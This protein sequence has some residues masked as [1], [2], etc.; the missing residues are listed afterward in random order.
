MG[1]EAAGKGEASVGCLEIALR[2][3]SV[4]RIDRRPD[5]E[6]GCRGTRHGMAQN[7]LGGLR[8]LIDSP[9][10]GGD[11]FPGPQEE[12]TRQGNPTEAGVGTTDPVQPVLEGEAEE[13]FGVPLGLALPLLQINCLMLQKNRQ[14]LERQAGIASFSASPLGSRGGR[15]GSPWGKSVGRGR[16]PQPGRPAPRL[17]CSCPRAQELLVSESEGLYLWVAPIG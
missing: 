2:A 4:A 12:K 13:V 16:G 1:D 15:E 11:M 3:E 17:A 14:Q 5:R 10:L 6:S 7:R 8:E 9:R